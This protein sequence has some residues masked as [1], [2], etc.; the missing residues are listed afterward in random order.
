M[1]SNQGFIRGNYYPHI[2]GIRAFAILPVLLYHAFPAMFPGGFIG[3]DV[4]FVI[5]GYLITR[6]LLADLDANKYSI[7][8]FYVRRIRRIFPAYA[9]VIIFS[10][11]AGGLIYYGAKLELLATTALSSIF[12]AT[13]IFFERTSDYF[14][15]EAHENALLNLWSLSV[16]EQ[17]YVFFPLFLALLYK[18]T[19][20]H[21]KTFIWLTFITSLILSIWVVNFKGHD[22]L[23]FYWLPFR[24]WELMAGSL[25]AIHINDKF[26]NLRTGFLSLC[27]LIFTIFCISDSTP[28]P[29]I[30]ASIP[31]LCAVSLI[32]SGK[33]GIAKTILEHRISVFIGKISYS[34]YLFHWPLLVF[35]R[36][37]LSEFLPSEIINW[38][39]IILSIIF[40]ILSWQYIELPLRRTKWK[41][42]SYYKLGVCI[43][44]ITLLFSLAMRQLAKYE[45]LHSHVIVEEYWDGEAASGEK[46]SDPHWPASENRTSN[47]LTKLGGHE[48]PQYVLWG[49]S[50]AMALAP[51]FNSFSLST[52][53]NGL[54]I[55]RKHTLLRGTN[56]RLYPDNSQW[57]E[58]ILEWL[59]KHP[60]LHT[61]I[62]VNR[63]AVRSQGWANE[64]GRK[65]VY[66]RLDGQGASSED[67]F[68]LGITQICAELKKMGK[69]VIIITSVPEQGMD[70]PEKLQRFGI[71]GLLAT[72]RGISEAEYDE[73]QHEANIVFKK[74]QDNNLAQIIWVKQVFFPNGQILPLLLP[75]QISMYRD[76]DH[77]SPSGAKY[78]INKIQGT[79]QQLILSHQQQAQ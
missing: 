3:V 70:V 43:I 45:K 38:I 41:N 32:A 40:S 77:L 25:L 27:I 39:A 35:S 34:L 29:G 49:D 55:N 11:I 65:V 53:I 78:L 51:G 1:T 42:T 72:S 61:V 20:R 71:F 15:P 8:T 13:N 60:E 69:Q 46:Y 9:A 33:Y 76:D 67:I 73:R 63:W 59:K 22:M 30:V 23:A 6:G 64:S 47:S 74:L 19:P 4:F 28:F 24:A 52:G 31:I 79:L 18:Y 5:S 75:G 58:Q 14:A 37:A 7:G 62:L 56:S 2:D 68:E 50:H 57:I 66:T 54:Y 21:I 17:F 36:Y 26:I 16:E 12:F 44:I 10:L 48:N